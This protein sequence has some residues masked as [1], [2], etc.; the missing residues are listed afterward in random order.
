MEESESDENE[1]NE[2]R[3]RAYNMVYWFN[4][5]FSFPFF[6]L[7]LETKSLKMK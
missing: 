6:F 7:I 5:P 3:I 4:F 1:G 2:E